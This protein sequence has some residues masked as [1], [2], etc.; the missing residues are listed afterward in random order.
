MKQSSLHV[1]MIMDGNGRWADRRGV[2]R[3]AGHRAGAEALRNVVEAAPSCGIDMLTVYAFSA[4]NWKRPFEEV[5]G[6]MTLMAGYLEG[7]VAQLA[8]NGVR[9]S[10]IGRRDRL[11]VRLLDAIHAAEDVTRTSRRLHLQ[12]A[13]D[14]SAREAILRAAKGREGR[15][16]TFR[17]FEELLG[18]TKPVDLLIRTGGEQRLSDFLL[19]ESAYAELVFTSCMWPDFNEVELRRAIAE[20]NRRDR[21]FGAVQ[22]SALPIAPA[23]VADSDVRWLH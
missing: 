17:G 4:D 9:V 3:L 7:E 21:R 18:Q 11:P 20:F 16:L 13:I 1:A 10:I 15:A 23:A 2:P 19:W 12:I 5:D 22:T 6:L 14:Y 8:A